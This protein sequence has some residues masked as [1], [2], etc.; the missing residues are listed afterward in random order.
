MLLQRLASAQQTHTAAGIFIKVGDE[1][2]VDAVLYK[3]NSV[4]AQTTQHHQHAV[5]CT[6]A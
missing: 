3:D 4:V 1:R 2:Q 5:L 6:Y